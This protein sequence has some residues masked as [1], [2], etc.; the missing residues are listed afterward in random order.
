MQNRDGSWAAFDRNNNH[1]IIEYYLRFRKYNIGMGRGLILDRG[2]ADLT[3][4]V[5][6]TLASFDYSKDHQEVQKA[7]KW[8]R[9]EQNTDGSW[10]G[11]WGLTYLYGT[12]AV[13]EAMHSLK[14]DPREDFIQ[15]A[16]HFLKACQN[17]DGGFGECPESYYSDDKKGKGVSTLTQTSW[18]VLALV[19]SGEKEAIEVKKALAFLLERLDRDDQPME[20]EFQAVAAPPLYQ[21]YEYYPYYFPLM[22][23]KAYREL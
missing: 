21:R 7:I 11:R 5:L 4:H 22:A 3:A 20:L 8:L 18:V 12:S 16:I 10:F 1:R 15:K 9:K 6:E 17:P 13:L 14:L 23:L 19:K 2:T